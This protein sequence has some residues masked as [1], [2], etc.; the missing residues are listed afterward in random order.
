MP[1]HVVKVGM[2]PVPAPETPAA[3]KL[4]EKPVPKSDDDKGASKN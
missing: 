1:A 3:P 4:E 2:Q